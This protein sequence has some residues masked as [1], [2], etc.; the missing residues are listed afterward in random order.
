MTFQS[1]I[2]TYTIAWTGSTSVTQTSVS[3]M[4]AYEAAK[5]VVGNTTNFNLTLA[6][7]TWFSTASS[8]TYGSAKPFPGGTYTAVVQASCIAK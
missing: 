6:G 2:L 5:T 1:Q 3:G 7:S 8:A 4:S